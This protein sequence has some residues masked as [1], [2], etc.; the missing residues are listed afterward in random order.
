MDHFSIR[1]RPNSFPK[2]NIIKISK[3]VK[4]G[5]EKITGKKL[6]E[7]T[8]PE[9]IIQ[10]T[11]PVVENVEEIIKEEISQPDR[12]YTSNRVNRRKAIKTPTNS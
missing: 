8:I 7:P 11:I 10:S 9:T 12:S 4:S 5:K 3:E 6:E 1:M 2:E